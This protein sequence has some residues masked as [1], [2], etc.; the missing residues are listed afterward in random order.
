MPDLSRPKYINGKLYCWD[1]AG[2]EIVEIRIIPV[3]FTGSDRQ[4][5]AAFVEDGSSLG[6]DKV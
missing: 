2:K 4:I 6:E 1:R 3:D 5:L